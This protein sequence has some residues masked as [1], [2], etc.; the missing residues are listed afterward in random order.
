MGNIRGRYFSQDLMYTYLMSINANLMFLEPPAGQIRFAS[1]NVTS[2]I[3][4]LFTD[5]AQ[6]LPGKY[7]S[8]GG[9]ELN[10]ECYANDTETLQIL[11]S[12]GQTLQQAL[13]VF[14]ET[15][16]GAL[17]KQGKTPVV[18]EGKTCSF[19]SDNKTN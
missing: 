3:S 4:S 1:P 7:F 18:W 8:T 19:A 12:T 11:N 15:T 5:I 16:H 17:E 13:N 10:T 9:D 6:V 2:F 14:I